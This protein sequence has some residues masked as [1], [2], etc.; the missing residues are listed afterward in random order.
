M[1]VAPSAARA[2]GSG[3]LFA[4][5]G[6]SIPVADSNWNQSAEPG[7]VVKAGA[8]IHRGIGAMATVELGDVHVSSAASLYPIYASDPTL[9]RLRVLG[10]LIYEQPNALESGFALT[11]HAGLGFDRVYAHYEQV[12]AAT[13]LP[14]S[15]TYNGLALELGAAVWFD[16]GT[17][18]DLGVALAIPI[19]T[20]SA[21]HLSGDPVG[22]NYTSF[23]LDLM[24]AVRFTSGD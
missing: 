21:T 6:V 5:G 15:E 8:A 9:R 16:L 14:H 4:G 23:D 12:I 19:A 10:H 17:G 20:H 3:F 11:L 24:A 13:A 1:L 7:P 2:E 18:I 22:F